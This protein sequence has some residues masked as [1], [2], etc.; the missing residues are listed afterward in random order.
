VHA[1][2]LLT[3]RSSETR[4]LSRDGESEEAILILW[5]EML[6]QVLLSK[7]SHQQEDSNILQIRLSDF[8]IGA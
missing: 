2:T 1:H 7:R 5:S 6:T 3:Q 8:K 4:I